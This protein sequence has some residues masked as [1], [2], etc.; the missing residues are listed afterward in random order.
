MST[1]LVACA[2]RVRWYVHNKTLSHHF[3]HLTGVSCY[4]SMARGSQGEGKAAIRC[5]GRD[6][7]PHRLPVSSASPDEA[8]RA[9]GANART[10]ANSICERSL[11]VGRVTGLLL[12]WER[13]RYAD[14]AEG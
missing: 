2:M 12:A 10:R 5:P 1:M 9:G 11:P 3:R 14:R 6:S 13:Q 4:G 7:N 8:T